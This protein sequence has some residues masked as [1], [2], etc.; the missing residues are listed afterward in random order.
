MVY[1]GHWSG[2]LLGGGVAIVQLTALLCSLSVGALT[3]IIYRSRYVAYQWII[4]LAMSL[5][6]GAWTSPE[7]YGHAPP[8][9]LEQWLMLPQS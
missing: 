7:G 8:E 4:Q 3:K 2:H 1:S 9:G 5:L 6:L